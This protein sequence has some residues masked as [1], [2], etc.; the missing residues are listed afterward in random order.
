MTDTQSPLTLLRNAIALLDNAERLALATWLTA[1]ANPKFR[2]LSELPD[3]E[4]LS[5][6]LADTCELSGVLLPTQKISFAIELLALQVD[7]K[8]FD[9]G[10]GLPDPS[11]YEGEEYYSSDR[12]T[13]GEDDDCY[14]HYEVETFRDR[15]L[16]Q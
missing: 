6:R 15:R 11:E 13:L 14:P 1:T 9:E 2:Y 16:D 3:W 8:A 12:P 7:R 5:S 4:K 10:S